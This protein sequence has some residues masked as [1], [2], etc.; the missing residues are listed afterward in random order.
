MTVSFSQSDEL[1]RSFH[2][3]HIDPLT[4][5]E[6]RLFRHII[7][8]GLGIR[9]TEQKRELIAAR[10][11]RR[12]RILNLESFGQYLDY[13]SKCPEEKEELFNRIST[14]ETA[15]LREPSQFEFLENHVA[16]L[17]EREAEAGPRSRKLR[18]WSAGCSTGEEPYSIA[19]TCLTAFPEWQIEILATDIST[20]ALDHAVKGEWPQAAVSEIPSHHLRRFVQKGV[21]SQAGRIRMKS[22]LRSVVRFEKLNLHSEV[23][24]AS[25][26]FDLIFCRNVLIYFDTE[27]RRA[28]LERLFSRLVPRG[29]IFLGHSESLIGHF[30]RFRSVA[31]S[32]YQQRD[33]VEVV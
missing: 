11:A 8:S 18:I 7:E 19:M 23:P 28:A 32:I 22:E 17:L 15:F 20:R 25:H 29:F 31:P 5:R 30:D 21:R 26:R 1:D 24:D 14:N 13:L 16:P 33:A 10:L 12:V 27:S 6:F 2:T 4:D 3:Y 9:V